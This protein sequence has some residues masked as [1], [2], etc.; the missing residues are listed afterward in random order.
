MAMSQTNSSPYLISKI[1]PSA[2]IRGK[3]GFQILNFKFQVILEFEI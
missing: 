1:R 2:K 3:T